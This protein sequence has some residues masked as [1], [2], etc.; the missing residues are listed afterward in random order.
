MDDNAPLN[1]AAADVAALIQAATHENLERTN[2][3]VKPDTTYSREWTK[4][5]VFIDQKRQENVVP[6]P[7]DL[8]LTQ[9]NMDLYFWTVVSWWKKRILLRW[10][11]YARANHAFN[12]ILSLLG[13]S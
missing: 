7:H 10:K 3:V 4:F 8:Y 13:I 11:T 1:D 12:T 6:L 2:T 5:K 9:D